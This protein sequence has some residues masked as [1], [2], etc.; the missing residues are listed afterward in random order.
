MA[1]AK[2]IN[3]YVTVEEAEAYFANKLDVAA[4]TDAPSVQK[5]QALVTATS[6]L[7]NLAWAGKAVEESQSLA[8]PRVV[9]YF[10]PKVGGYVYNTG[11][12]KRI[13]TATFELAYHLLNNDGLLDETGSV[14]TLTVGPITLTDVKSAGSIPLLVKNTVRPLLLNAGSNMW[15]RAN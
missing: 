4:W 10:D 12:P 6:L 9:E 8:F 1:L 3:S 7:D 15:W 14:K 13:L 5:E 11:T 2:G